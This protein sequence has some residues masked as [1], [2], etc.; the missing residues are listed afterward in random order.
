[1]TQQHPRPPRKG[2][3][4]AGWTLAVL[5]ALIVALGVVMY[6]YI[7]YLLIAGIHE[8]A[9]VQNDPNSDG[10]KNFATTY[11]DDCERTACQYTAYYMWNL[12]N[13]PDVIN[14]AKPKFQRLG[15]Y[16]YLQKKDRIIRGFRNDDQEVLY[17]T[18]NRYIFQPDMSVGTEADLITNVNVV[19]ASAMWQAGGLERNLDFVLTEALL[20]AAVQQF[21]SPAFV[22]KVYGAFRPPVL[23]AA[24]AA[25]Q[26]QTDD[27]ALQV[28][29]TNTSCVPLFNDSS[30]QQRFA[31]LGIGLQWPGNASVA[32]TFL[33]PLFTA[34]SPVSILNPAAQ[35]TVW[36]GACVLHNPASVGALKQAFGQSQ[37]IVDQLCSYYFSVS[38]TRVAPAAFHHF[39]VSS[40]ADLAL[41]EWGTGTVSN[42]SAIP[43]QANFYL[44]WG[45]FV[46]LQSPDLSLIPVPGSYIQ[47]PQARQML[48]TQGPYALLNT[49]AYIPFVTNAAQG[50]NVSAYG[51]SADQQPYVQAYML[52]LAW[53]GVPWLKKAAGETIFVTRTVKDWLWTCYDPV[54]QQ[55]CALQSDDTAPENEISI[56]KTGKSGF[57]EDALVYVQWQNVS[58]IEG[59]WN[60]TDGEPILGTDGTR[61]RPFLQEIEGGRHEGYQ[62]VSLFVTELKRSVHLQYEQDVDLHGATLWRYRLEDH[63]LA[64]NP[65]YWQSIYGMGN[66]SLDF[67]GP[68]FVSKPSF[69]E[70]DPAVANLVEGMGETSEIRDDTLLDVEPYT[71][72]VFRAYKRL[73]L[74]VQLPS[75]WTWDSPNKKIYSAFYP[76]VVVEN[77]GVATS[78]DVDTFKQSVYFALTMMKVVLYT[79]LGVG[80]VAMATGMVLLLIR[81]SAVRRGGNDK[82]AEHAQHKGNFSSGSA[83]TATMQGDKERESL[84]HAYQS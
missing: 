83:P 27:R 58:R 73:Q 66:L 5:G 48:S 84:I 42:N 2:L 13:A 20:A 17:S 40:V 26:W 38:N 77:Y 22:Q 81:S 9:W 32:R 11:N 6:Y 79:G 49:T 31:G 43:P 68:I 75:T 24:Y 52:S 76:V 14:G 29:F 19:Y 72:I 7:R 25:T 69:Y 23:S 28:I 50:L 39:G 18:F 82:S 36:Y 1:M 33:G 3:R 74:N 60:L 63:V 56:M 51:F 12:K 30:C 80:A 35:D 64:P 46:T 62:R 59:V 21:Q 57:G 65:S 67:Q 8:Q 16:T 41:L 54:V 10:Y 45:T 61:F 78:H 34:A 71:G 44:S 37:V 55:S 47:V 70:V 4:I 15:P 53:A